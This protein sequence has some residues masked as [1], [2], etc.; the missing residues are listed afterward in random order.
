MIVEVSMDNVSHEV[1]AAWWAPGRN[2]L[3]DSVLVDDRTLVLT[4]P[5]DYSSP[6]GD[7]GVPWRVVKYSDKEQ[8]A[9]HQADSIKLSTLRHFR[10]ESIPNVRE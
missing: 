3:A 7:E 1:R 6:Y 9:P 5:V 4:F 8:Y 10:E 2:G